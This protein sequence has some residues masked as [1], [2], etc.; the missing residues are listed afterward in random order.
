MLADLLARDEKQ[1][2]DTGLRHSEQIELSVN[3]KMCADCHAFFK[4]ASALLG[5]QLVVRE[6]SLT[7][8][9]D[10]GD[11]SCGD[12]WRCHRAPAHR[13]HAHSP[14]LDLFAP[15][16]ESTF[17]HC[18]ITELCCRESNIQQY[19]RETETRYHSP[20][21]DGEKSCLLRPSY[22][23]TAIPVCRTSFRHSLYSGC[24]QQ[25]VSLLNLHSLAFS[26]TLC[27]T[28]HCT[29]TT[30]LPAV[31]P[32]DQIQNAVSLTSLTPKE[33]PPA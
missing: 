2:Q 32:A 7:H 18:M 15:R 12:R 8:I 30:S 33:P 16:G 25:H 31:P 20:S 21:D 24:T 5:R 10:G 3:F 22:A 19:R 29:T 23:L 4:G 27:S 26:I 6:P 28:P 14:Q 9:F 13:H 17:K 11:C 1:F